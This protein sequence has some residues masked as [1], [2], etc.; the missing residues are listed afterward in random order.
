MRGH[1]FITLLGGAAASG[2]L[3]AHTQ[4]PDRMRRIGVLGFPENDSE[5]QAGKW[6]DL[7]EEV[8]PP[9]TGLRHRSTRQRPRLEML[10]N[11]PFSS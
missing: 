6:L 3:A 9:V 7:L 2:P 4:H 10:A 5:T 1:E 8:A 11:E